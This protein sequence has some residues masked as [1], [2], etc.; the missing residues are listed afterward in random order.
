MLKMK[1][2]A[3]AMPAQDVKR[4]R[5]FYEQ[6]LGLK[7]FQESPDG[8]AMYAVGDTGFLVFPSTGKSSG[9]HTQM[10]VDVDDVAEAVGELKRAGVKIEEYDLPGF[11]TQDGL[12]DLPDGSKGAFF[13]D[14]EGNLIGL[15]TMVPAATRS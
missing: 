7:P 13:K 11:K 2:V 15:G 14:T 10:A 3:A 6:K 4:A 12:I 8:G 5:Q 9:N 1:R